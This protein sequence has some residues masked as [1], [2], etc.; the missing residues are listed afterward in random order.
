VI[1]DM[2]ILD[3][4]GVG[5]GD[6]QSNAGH[7]AEDHATETAETE[8]IVPNGEIEDIVIP[9]EIGE[10]SIDDKAEEQTN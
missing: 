2:I 10:M 9:D 4:K 5:Y 7:V 6:R 8:M 3:N 1:D